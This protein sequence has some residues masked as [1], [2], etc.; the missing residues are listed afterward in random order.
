MIVSKVTTGFV[1]Q[2]FNDETG[3]FIEQSV[4]V[5]DDVQW[6]NDEGEPVGSRDYYH[7]YEMKGEG[8]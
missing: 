6:E 7:S 3:A 1:V 5:G 2:K 4:I 8:E